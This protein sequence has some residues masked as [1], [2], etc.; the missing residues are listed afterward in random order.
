MMMFFFLELSDEE[1]IIRMPELDYTP[2]PKGLGHALFC[3]MKKFKNKTAQVSS[4]KLPI[5]NTTLTCLERGNVTKED[6]ESV[7][8]ENFYM[9]IKDVDLTKFF[10]CIIEAKKAIDENGK[11]SREAL[12]SDVFN[13]LL[14]MYNK[15]GDRDIANKI[16]DECVNITDDILMNR[17]M[18]LH[19]CLVDAV[20]TH[21]LPDDKSIFLCLEKGNVTI[22]DV[23][24]SFDENFH[25][26]TTDVDFT[27]FLECLIE[28]KNGMDE[29]GKIS[30]DSLRN[31]VLNVLLPMY[32]KKGDLN[33][34]ASKVTDECVNIEDDVLTKRIMK[35]HNCLVD[36]V[37]KY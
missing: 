16:T 15:K 1:K 30:R 4:F 19:N 9:T 13:I 17:M 10:E 28:V 7:F 35:L 37:N 33:E 11:I 23:E 20:L 32:D 21:K 36:A 3:S 18:K 12:F 25:M 5:D 31:D 8:D 2:D 6:V 27:K 34:I 14:P 26:I 29:S 24:N 22:E